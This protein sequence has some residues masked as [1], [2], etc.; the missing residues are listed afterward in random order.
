MYSLSNPLFVITLVTT[1]LLII[2]FFKFII[3]KTKLKVY[4]ENPDHE[5]NKMAHEIKSL[6]KEKDTQKQNFEKQLLT[7]ERNLKYGIDILENTVKEKEE[8]ISDLTNQLK[9]VSVSL[10]EVTENFTKIYKEKEKKE[11]RFFDGVA[12]LSSFLEKILLM[13]RVLKFVPDHRCNIFFK[14][15]RA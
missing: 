15:R 5:Y 14:T 10:S 4:E 11:S 2:Y 1:I 8:Q 9:T 13:E 6:T 12:I 7:Q 3:I